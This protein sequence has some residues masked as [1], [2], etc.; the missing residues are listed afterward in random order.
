MFAASNPDEDDGYL[1]AINIHSTTSFEE[2]VKAT[3]LS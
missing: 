1:G 2:E 3:V